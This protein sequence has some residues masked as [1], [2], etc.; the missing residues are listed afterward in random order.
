MKN[1]PNPVGV[2]GSKGK[3]FWWIDPLHVIIVVVVVVV[4]VDGDDDVVKLLVSLHSA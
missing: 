3:I 1:T 2:L 4:V